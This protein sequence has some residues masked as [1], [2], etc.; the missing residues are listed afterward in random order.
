ML[1]EPCCDTTMAWAASSKNGSRLFRSAE[2]SPLKS[3]L[4]SSAGSGS[5]IGATGPGWSEMKSLT[6][7]I[8]GV[9]MNAHCTRMGSPPARNSMSP[10]PTSCSAPL[11]SRMVLESTTDVT[12]KAI[13]PGKLALMLPVI[14]F[15]VGR[16]VAIT[17]CMPTARASCAIRAIGSSISLPAVM[18]RSPNSS[19]M[20]TM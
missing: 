5:S 10:L 12:R 8:S 14:I 20:T 19:M 16:W 9:S 17:M 2:P 13:R 1:V 11:R 4:P 6:F 3:P 15:V 18:M 7:S